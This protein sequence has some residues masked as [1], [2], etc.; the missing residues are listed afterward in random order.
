MVVVIMEAAVSGSGG[1]SGMIY[2][3]CLQYQ[4]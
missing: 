1:D 4:Q 3:Q 2:W